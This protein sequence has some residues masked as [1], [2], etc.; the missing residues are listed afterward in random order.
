MGFLWPDLGTSLGIG[1]NLWSDSG[2]SSGIGGILYLGFGLGVKSRSECFSLAL[3]LRSNQSQSIPPQYT[4]ILGSSQGQDVL[5]L[6][7]FLYRQEARDS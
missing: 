5:P 4:L 6:T 2:A 3:D 7:P 1:G